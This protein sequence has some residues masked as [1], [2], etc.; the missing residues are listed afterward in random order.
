MTLAS[1]LARLLLAAPRL[2]LLLLDPKAFSFPREIPSFLSDP[3]A[4][5]ALGSR[6]PIS[7]L[8]RRS[9]SPFLPGE[10]FLSIVFGRL[11]ER[12]TPLAGLALR[13]ENQ[14]AFCDRCESF[15]A[16][17][18]DVAVTLYGSLAAPLW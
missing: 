5:Q 13:P 15:S 12:L 16:C 2:E 4:F 8:S 7:S 11:L 14:R 6:S 18:G 1:S 17:P 10:L 9:A 3:A